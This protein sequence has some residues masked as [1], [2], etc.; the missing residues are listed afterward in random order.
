LS[1]RE[2][3]MTMLPASIADS[4]KALRSQSDVLARELNTIASSVKPEI[5]ESLSR[6]RAIF[7]DDAQ[8]LSWYTE[9][10]EAQYRD[11]ATAVANEVK[12]VNQYAK[13]IASVTNLAAAQKLAKMIQEARARVAALADDAKVASVPPPDAVTT[14]QK[15]RDSVWASQKKQNALPNLQGYI[16]TW[17]DK[18]DEVKRTHAKVLSIWKEDEATLEWPP[19]DGGRPAA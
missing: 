6:V 19:K 2:L 15:Y 13:D 3:A 4:V 1:A 18:A 8:A 10:L 12:Q 14:L 16:N 5:P 7:G 11:V 9:K 17:R